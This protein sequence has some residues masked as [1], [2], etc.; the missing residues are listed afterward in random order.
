[1]ISPCLVC[2]SRAV[3]RAAAMV[4][5]SALAMVGVPIERATSHRDVVVIVEP[6]TGRRR[7]NEPVDRRGASRRHLPTDL[8]A[9]LVLDDYGSCT[10]RRSVV[11]AEV[12][13]TGKGE[14]RS[15]LQSASRTTHSMGAPRE[16]IAVLI[17]EYHGRSGGDDVVLVLLAVLAVLDNDDNRGLF[18]SVKGLLPVRWVALR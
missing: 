3:S 9:V 15:A 5:P 7:T 14:D 2:T 12:A 16:L 8:T 18:I 6:C 13:D 17:L 10:P 4:R 1:M 11:T